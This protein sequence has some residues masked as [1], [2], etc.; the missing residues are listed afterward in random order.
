ME[1]TSSLRLYTL[2]ARLVRLEFDLPRLNVSY[3]ESKDV[4]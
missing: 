3:V 1:T 2:L 4:G